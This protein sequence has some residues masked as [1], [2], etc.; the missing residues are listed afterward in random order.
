M[1]FWSW[2]LLQTQREVLLCLTWTLRKEFFGLILVLKYACIF[3]FGSFMLWWYWNACKTCNTRKKK[4]KKQPSF[5]LKT[6][7]YAL[8]C[9]FFGLC[10]TEILVRLKIYRLQTMTSPTEQCQ[11]S[12]KSRWQRCF[13]IV[14]LWKHHK[15][16]IRPPCCFCFK[17]KPSVVEN[18]L[19]EDR[20]RHQFPF[21]RQKQREISNR[22]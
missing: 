1:L 10:K 18:P 11:G 19:K 7:F 13:N 5:E 8:T 2:I 3:L 21:T 14:L 15:C 12:R 6:T 22:L 20:W 17:T 4:R 9:T 16:L